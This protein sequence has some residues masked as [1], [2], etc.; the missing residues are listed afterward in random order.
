[1][2]EQVAERRARWPGRLVEIDDALLGGD[3]TRVAP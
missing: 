2:G 1:M 3:E